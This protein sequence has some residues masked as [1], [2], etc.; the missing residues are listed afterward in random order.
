MEKNKIINFLY[1]HPYP[2][3][4]MVLPGMVV[5][6]TLLLLSFLQPQGLIIIFFPYCLLSTYL[7]SSITSQIE[8]EGRQLGVYGLQGTERVLQPRR[9]IYR[10]DAVGK[11]RK[12]TNHRRGNIRCVC[13]WCMSGEGIS[14]KSNQGRLDL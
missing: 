12:Q 4:V 1:M 9:E 6:G 2:D 10:R 11:R 7:P 5:V 14:W 8:E 3:T 13:V